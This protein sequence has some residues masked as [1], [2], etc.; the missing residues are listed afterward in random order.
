MR[1]KKVIKGKNC[2]LVLFKD[3]PRLVEMIYDLFNEKEIEEFLNPSYLK[4]NT[5]SKI[6]KW[7]TK[8]TN[9]PVEVWYIIKFKSRSIG[10]VCFK[11]RKHYDEAC[12]IST[13]ILK[14]YRGLKLGYESSKLIVEYILS[15]NKFKYVVGY[16]YKTNF[17][18]ASNLRKLGFKMANRLQKIVTT[19]FYGEDN[20]EGGAGRY[21]LM[22]IYTA[23]K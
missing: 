9:N 12:E 11:W 21:N 7:I 22:A 19:K 8:K 2:S 23:D 13:A 20:S 4:H 5:K 16:V 15:I 6:K 17:K 1:F 10:Y 3:D 18:A 14:E